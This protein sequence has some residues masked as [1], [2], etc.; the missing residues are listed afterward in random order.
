MPHHGLQMPSTAVTYSG[1]VDPS[2][3]LVTPLQTT[4]RLSGL[5]QLA[6][7]LSHVHKHIQQA[8]LRVSGR[9]LPRSDVPSSSLHLFSHSQSSNLSFGFHHV[10]NLHNDAC[11][12]ELSAKGV[13]NH[14]RSLCND[15][16]SNKLSASTSLLHSRNR[17]RH[18]DM[19]VGLIPQLSSSQ[20]LCFPIAI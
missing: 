15:A 11:S 10:H 20:I 16:C 13:L 4:A 17:G 6:L 8:L 3:A 9:A 12:N 7:S 2:P 14:L 1:S 19:L 5:S 18:S